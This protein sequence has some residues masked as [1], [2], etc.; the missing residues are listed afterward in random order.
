VNG[1]Q[2]LG[3]AH[4]FGPVLPEADEP[5][6]HAEWERRVLALT[7]AAGAAGTWNLDQARFARESIPP[8]RYLASSYYEIWLAGL[9]RLLV[10]HGMVTP[11][12][13]GRGHAVGPAPPG[14]RRLRADEVAQALSSRRGSTARPPSAVAR[15]APGDPVRARVMHPAGH[16]RLP[17]YVRGR[18]G[19]VEAVHGCH[20]FP[21]HHALGLGEDPQWL[22][23]VVF[24]GPELWGADTD[25]TVTVSVDA[26]EPYLEP[27]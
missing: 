15:F 27:A 8:A 14:G 24:D 17:R 25:P 10:D 2:D 18:A 23:T 6:F 9:E 20:V 4:G 22:Y 12:E 5:V 3:G 1:P 21:D 16:T 13:L 11:D 7:L 19:A 26:F